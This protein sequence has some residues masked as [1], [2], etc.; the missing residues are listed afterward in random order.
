M[1]SSLIATSSSNQKQTFFALFL[2]CFCFDY[3]SCFFFVIRADDNKE[4]ILTDMITSNLSTQESYCLCALGKACSFVLRCLHQNGRRS[5]SSES[6]EV[7]RV[8]Q[9]I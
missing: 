6:S 2:D 4:L 1:F 8:L 7:I 9:V 3:I 5:H